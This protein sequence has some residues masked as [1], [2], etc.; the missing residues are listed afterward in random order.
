MKESGDD[1]SFS[2]RMEQARYGNQFRLNTGRGHERYYWERHPGLDYLLACS[3]DNFA[4]VSFNEKLH[5][6]CFYAL[7]EGDEM[8]DFIVYAGEAAVPKDQAV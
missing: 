5:L 8:C 1:F 3:L 6:Q 4:N 7:M 2:T